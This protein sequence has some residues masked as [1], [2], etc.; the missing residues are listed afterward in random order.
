MHSLVSQAQFI[1]DMLV[2]LCQEVRLGRTLSGCTCM[3]HTNKEGVMCGV[4]CSPTFTFKL[5]QYC[6]VMSDAQREE[7]VSTF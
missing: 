2:G 3:Y 5:I 7:H 1:Y 6:P 4:M